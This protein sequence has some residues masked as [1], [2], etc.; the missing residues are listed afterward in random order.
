MTLRYSRQYKFSNLTEK[1]DILK[2]I[3]DEFPHLQEA[4][5]CLS[6]LMLNAVEH[7]NLGVGFETKTSY[8]ESGTPFDEMI[9]QRLL[10]SEFSTR[11]AV[12]KLDV[13][14]DETV[15]MICDEGAGFNWKKYLDKSLSEVSGLHGR[16]I[17][18]AEMT[19][20]TLTYIGCGNKVIAV[21]NNDSVESK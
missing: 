2:D 10:F 9:S 20:K 17:L 6:E 11:I 14:H 4:E 18:M 13:F 5:M 3:I 21:F 8:I 16:G 7:G 12:L 1:V 15:I 19:C